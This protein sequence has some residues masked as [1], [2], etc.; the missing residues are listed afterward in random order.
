M[1]HTHT[2]SLSL[3]VCVCVVFFW[4]RTD[5]KPDAGELTPRFLRYNSA[6]RPGGWLDQAEPSIF[7]ISDYVDLGSDH[8][9]PQW[10]GLMVEASERA[11]LPFDMVGRMKSGMEDAGFINVTEVRVPWPI[12]RWPQDE[13]QQEIGLLNR[14]RLEKGIL[15]FC[16]RR[17]SNNLGVLIFLFLSCPFVSSVNRVNR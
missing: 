12:G 3:S 17:F 5:V 2:H 8:V 14:A 16:S 11:G 13:R 10:G 1:Y 9:Y 4:C 15:D 7:L 6:L